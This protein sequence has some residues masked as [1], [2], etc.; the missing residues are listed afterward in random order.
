MVPTN[1]FA[2]RARDVVDESGLILDPV[3]MAPYLTSWRD[4]WIG[5]A[6]AVLRPT[7]TQQVARVVALCRDMSIP[8]VP[9]GGRTGVTGASQPNESGDEI[10]LSLERMK[11]IRSIDPD[12]DTMTVEAGCVLADVRAA[13]D[14]AGRI[15][16]LSF[17]SVGSCQIGGNIATNAGGVNVVRYGNTRSLIAGLEIVLPS[18]EIWDG[19]R[20][21]RKDNAGYDLKQIFIGSEGT[22]GI[23]T[24]AVIRLFPRPFGTA[25]AFTSTPSPQAALKLLSRMRERFAEQLTSF[26][27]IQQRCIEVTCRR[28]PSL[29][30]PLPDG[31]A[32]HLL[33]E[34]AGQDA[35]D[36]L[37]VRLGEVLEAALDAGEI[38]DAVLAQSR[39]QERE[40]WLLRESIPE[41]HKHE[42]RSFKHDISVPISRISVFLERAEAALKQ[43][44]PDLLMFTFGH[45]GDGN[46]HFNPL[47]P[48]GRE[49]F[50]D[51]LQAVNTAVHDLVVELG[52]SISAE[53]GIGRLRRDELLHYK[54]SVE[55]RM[56]ATLKSAFD[57]ENLFNRGKI[58]SESAHAD[59]PPTG[60][61]ATV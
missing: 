14:A 32:W 38:E 2:D 10:V 3:E 7:D 40:F 46:L 12:N 42:G 34:I 49:P 33:I 54:S 56:M 37:Q 24:A 16:P 39:H 23:I 44:D 26:E 17:G 57:P 5:K 1:L 55:L 51:E 15:F 28:I 21:L 31:G 43:I 4:N 36:V 47:L 45:L 52:G 11:R 61:P 25:V 9:Q 41:A 58:L 48:P 6:R 19:L 13:A 27:L 60:R 30:K 18:G 59:S 50:V 22:L 20:G 53:H 35:D 8:I 29:R